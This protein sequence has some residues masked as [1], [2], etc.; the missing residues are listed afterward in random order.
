MLEILRNAIRKTRHPIFLRMK[1]FCW[2]YE[3]SES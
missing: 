1:V 2:I 3:V